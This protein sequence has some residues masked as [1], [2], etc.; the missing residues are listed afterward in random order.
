MKSA[1][2]LTLS[3]AFFREM[4]TVTL[5]KVLFSMYGLVVQLARGSHCYMDRIGTWRPAT[6]SNPVYVCL[7]L[8]FF[9]QKSLISSSLFWKIK[10]QDDMLAYFTSLR[11]ISYMSRH[12]VSFSK[13]ILKTERFEKRR[14][15]DNHVRSS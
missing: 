9:F 15:H 14:S 4:K 8:F 2:D 1:T 10:P 13:N 12:F 3:Y 7:H 11:I 6:G 5:I